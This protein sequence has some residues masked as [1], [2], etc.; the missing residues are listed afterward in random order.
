MCRSKERPARLKR[1]K[2][3]EKMHRRRCGRGSCGL[4]LRMGYTFRTYFRFGLFA[5]Q[6]SELKTPNSKLTTEGKRGK[7]EEGRGKREEGRGDEKTGKQR[8]FVYYESSLLFLCLSLFF[9]KWYM[10]FAPASA[11]C[12][13]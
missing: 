4:A 10:R 6:K 2:K 12:S 8:S 11:H 5:S 13:H 7:R 3:E 1:A 9:V